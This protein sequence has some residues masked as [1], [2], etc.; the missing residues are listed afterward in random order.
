MRYFTD[1][2]IDDDAAWEQAVRAYRAR[3][4]RIWARLPPEA[5]AL[6]T[7]PLLQLDGG[8]IREFAISSD[9]RRIRLELAVGNEGVGYR[10]LQLRMLDAR[11]R[12]DNLYL[13]AEAIGAV[14][15]PNHWHPRRGFTVI[16]YSELDVDR[17][18]LVLRFRLWPFH[19]VEINA[20]Q[21]QCSWEASSG[22]LPLRAGRFLLDAE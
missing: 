6:F 22:R 14:F 12:P 13:L 8:A 17:E 2:A 15:G 19:E 16:R 10:V 1:S 9:R 20:A 18:R 21:L 7:D 3:I 11:I 4:R 5:R